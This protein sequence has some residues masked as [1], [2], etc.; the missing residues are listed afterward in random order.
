MQHG[1]LNNFMMTHQHAE[2]KIISPKKCETLTGPHYL[3]CGTLG[4]RGTIVEEH[5]CRRRSGL[6]WL[7]TFLITINMSRFLLKVSAVCTVQQ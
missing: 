5:C 2:A 4:F 7:W 3:F 1:Y 6:T